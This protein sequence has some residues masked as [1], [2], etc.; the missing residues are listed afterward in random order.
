MRMQTFWQTECFSHT[1]L[2]K[3]EQNSLHDK[4]EDPHLKNLCQSSAH[5][6]RR[7]IFSTDKLFPLACRYILFG[8]FNFYFLFSSYYSPGSYFRTVSA[9]F[10]DQCLLKPWHLLNLRDISSPLLPSD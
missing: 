4:I 5:Q 2:L 6:A 1:I 10:D 7:I 9:S 8:R 3:I